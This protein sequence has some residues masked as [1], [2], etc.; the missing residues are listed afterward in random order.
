VSPPRPGAALWLSRTQEWL[1]HPG[2]GV[3]PIDTVGAGDSFLARLMQV[4]SASGFK[5][6]F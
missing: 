4:M 1:E 6:A 5:R 3:T 2:F